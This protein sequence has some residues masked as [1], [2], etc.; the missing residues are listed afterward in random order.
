MTQS[1][2]GQQR[3]I[4]DVIVFTTVEWAKFVEEIKQAA[5]QAAREATRAAMQLAPRTPCR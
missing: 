3:P 5:K 1:A 4:D 2:N